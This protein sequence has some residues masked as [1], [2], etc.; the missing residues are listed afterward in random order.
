MGKIKEI[1]KKIYKENDKKT[2]LVFIILRVLIII[3]MIRELINGDY[4]NAMFCILSLFLF[5]LPYI[6][7]KTFKI[8]FPSS[9]ERIVFAFIFSAEILGEINNFYGTVP[10]WD[11]AL[12]TTSGFL[13]GSLGFSLIY[14]LNKK[15][16]RIKLSPI[17]VALVSFC[18]SMTVGIVW[19]MFE[20]GMDIVFKMDMQKDE[21]VEVINTVDLDPKFD[22]N[23]VTVDG[24]D[25]TIVYDANGNKL[26]EFDG[27]LDIGLHDTM[28][29][30]I[31][32]FI[33]AATFSIFGYL[34][35]K[36]EKKYKLVGNLMTTRNENRSNISI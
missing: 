32:N 29:D 2:I 14:L 7:E 24:I 1:I 19:E 25:Y 8:D 4:T 27:Y 12:H 23:V 15:T 17:F 26:V 28:S 36:N 9:L 21:Y 22:N 5:L 34:Y 31:V 20:Y 10:F 18:F 16:K 33:G 11:I 6:I 13:C 30:L 35:V 3:C